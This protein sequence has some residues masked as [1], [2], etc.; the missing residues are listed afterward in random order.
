MYELGAINTRRKGRV[1]NRVAE[2]NQSVRSDL[3][4][5]IQPIRG[6]RY[7]TNRNTRNSELFHEICYA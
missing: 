4:D 1:R 2:A 3:R 6:L 7:A 5:K